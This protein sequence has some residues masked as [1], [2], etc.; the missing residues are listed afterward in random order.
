[1]ALSV[2][3]FAGVPAFAAQ[4]S[5]G[6]RIGPPPRPR[7]VRVLPRRPGP[8]FIWIEGYWYPEGRVYRWHDG[9]WT[10]SPY[11]RAHWVAP[12]HDGEQYFVGYWDGNQGRYEHD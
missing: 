6:I 3:L 8:E 5:I 10:R 4:L 2:I 12:R 1:M 9:Y 7:V 11:A